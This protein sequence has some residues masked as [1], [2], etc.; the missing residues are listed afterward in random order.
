MSEQH[1]QVV[2][3]SPVHYGI[4]RILSPLKRDAWL[5]MTPSER[6]IR[7]WNLRLQLKDPEAVHDQKLFPKP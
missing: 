5:K 3:E 2:R 1:N 6:L 4:D 7:S